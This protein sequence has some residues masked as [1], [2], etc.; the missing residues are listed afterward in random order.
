MHYIT[1]NSTLECA[2]CGRHLGMAAIIVYVD[3]EPVCAMCRSKM[4]LHED[5]PKDRKL[6]PYQYGSMKAPIVN[7]L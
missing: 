4:E 6:E 2:Y 5:D 7:G 1:S 3:G